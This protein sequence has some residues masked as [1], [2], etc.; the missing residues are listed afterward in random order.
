MVA[1][2]ARK[3]GQRCHQRHPGGPAQ[4]LRLER[5]RSWRHGERVAAGMCRGGVPRRAFSGCI[6]PAPRHDGGGH[7]LHPERFRLGSRILREHDDRCAIR[8]RRRRRRRRGE[9][10]VAGVHQRGDTGAHARSPLERAAGH[11]HLRPHG[12]VSRQLCAGG[13]GRQIDR[14]LLAR[15]RGLALDVLDADSAGLCVPADVAA[16]SGKPAL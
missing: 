5:G 3:I 16:D 10:P 15:I 13:Q 9:R 11:D 7:S 1:G 4:H 2:R 14:C 8:R 12:R 6:W